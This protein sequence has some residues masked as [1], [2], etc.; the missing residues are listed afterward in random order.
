MVLVFVAIFNYLIGKPS[1]ITKSRRK[2]PK[3]T[4]ITTDS[5]TIFAAS[6]LAANTVMRSVVGAAFPLFIPYM[7]RGLGIHWATMVPG[8]L[9]VV[10][11]PFPFLFY[12]YGAQ[13]RGKCKYAAQSEAFMRRMKKEAEEGDGDSA[14]DGSSDEGDEKEERKTEEDYVTRGPR[15]VIEEEE[16]AQRLA[17]IDAEAKRNEGKE[18][19]EEVEEPIPATTTTTTGSGLRRLDSNSSVDTQGQPRFERIKSTRSRASSR[20]ANGGNGLVRVKTYE[21][22]PFDLDRVNTRESFVRAKTL[23]RKT[24]RTKGD[25][26]EGDSRGRQ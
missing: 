26:V 18:E 13:I 9:A 24:S 3:L 4:P 21:S 25:V 5:Y 19:R 23:S 15:E 8:F 7:Y 2:N 17:A 22:N 11:V 10:C 6:V 20:G 12:K 14:E 1:K 16:E